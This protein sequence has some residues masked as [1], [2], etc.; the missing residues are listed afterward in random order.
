[1]IITI[2]GYPGS[3]KSTLGKGIAES[4]GLKH[5]SAGD[6]LREIA[7]ERGM[8]LLQILRQMEKDESIDHEIDE[9]T[10]KLGQKEDNFVIDGRM[11]WH[12]IP[13]SVKIFVKIDLNEAAKRIYADCLAGK[14]ERQNEK[15]NLSLA[16]TVKN[17]EERL[18]L[19]QKAYKRLY[20]V[21]YL[22]EKNYDMVVD[23]TKTGIG[24]TRAKVLKQIK[25][26]L[27]KKQ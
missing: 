1:M 16:K 17:L 11:A 15:E 14:E 6:F 10:K 7:K 21:D 5:Y 26:Y 4:L 19:N 25:Q 24:E 12:F 2:T 8:S 18:K 13:K 22:D 23:T 20:S 3:G 9:R 27:S